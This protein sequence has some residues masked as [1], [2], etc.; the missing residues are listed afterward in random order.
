MTS[1][2]DYNIAN[3]ARLWLVVQ[4]PHPFITDIKWTDGET[5]T[6]GKKWTLKDNSDHGATIQWIKTVIAE[7]LSPHIDLRGVYVSM[8]ENGLG[9]IT[10]SWNGT[11]NF[12]GRSIVKII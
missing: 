2:P 12:M 8:D 6:S 1:M 3:W 11:L 5:W 4:M 7:C 9:P 10:A